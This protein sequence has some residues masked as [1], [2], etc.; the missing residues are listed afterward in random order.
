MFLGLDVRA[1]ETTQ[2]VDPS[3]TRREFD[4]RVVSVP[5]RRSAELFTER[6]ES[7]DLDLYVTLF[8]GFRV[9][10]EGGDDRRLVATGSSHRK[11]SKGVGVVE[12]N[13]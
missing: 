11:R 4:H 1:H 12:A 5:P 9:R 2:L 8:S 7:L 13:R 10:A 3:L 6:T